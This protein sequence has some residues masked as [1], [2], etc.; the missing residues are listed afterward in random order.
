[1]FPKAEFR[2]TSDW[3]DFGNRLTA[4]RASSASM[5]DLTN[6]YVGISKGSMD[7]N[8]TISLHSSEVFGS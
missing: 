6:V 8:G 5:W 1:M 4:G 7:D 2:S 3:Q